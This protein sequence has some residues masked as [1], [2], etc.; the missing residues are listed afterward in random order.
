MHLFTWLS[1][2]HAKQEKNEGKHEQNLKYWD[3]KSKPALLK[4]L[5]NSNTHNGQQL[6]V[7]HSI[8]I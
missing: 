8:P 7:T 3:K 5:L 6:A 1:V 4:F 2:N